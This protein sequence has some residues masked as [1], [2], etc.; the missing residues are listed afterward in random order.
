MDKEG[1]TAVNW[2][3]DQALSEYNIIHIQ[4]VM[5]SAAQQGRTGALDEAVKSEAGNLLHNR[6]QSGMQRRHS[7]S[8]SQ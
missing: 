2:L 1:E 6:Q 5:G 3:K 8:F 7:R 4:G